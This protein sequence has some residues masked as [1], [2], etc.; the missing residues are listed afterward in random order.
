MLGSKCFIEYSELEIG[1]KLG[2]GGYGEV[3]V[4]TWLG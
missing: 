2:E 4:G 1:K 3:H